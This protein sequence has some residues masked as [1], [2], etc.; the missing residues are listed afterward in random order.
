MEPRASY[1]IVGL[2][3]ISLVVVGIVGAFWLSTGKGPKESKFYVTYMSESVSGLNVQAPVKFNGV[4]VGTVK[5]ITIN[6][7]NS[8]QVRLLLSIE[9]DTPINQSTHA[10]L[11]TQGV[12]GV[13]FVGLKAG[14]ATA[15][16]LEIKPGEQYPVIPS[17]PSV[18][19]EIGTVLRK[20]TEDIG[21]ISKSFNELFSDE[22]QKAIHD[23]LQHLNNALQSSQSVLENF[24]QQVMPS[25]MNSMKQF[26]NTMNRM[27]PVVNTLQ[28]NP[29]ALI[30]GKEPDA[31]GP[32]EK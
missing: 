8:Q 5:E 29:S 18:L 24:K 12:T 4:T 13:M 28:D 17:E 25:L 16:P 20:I 15:P 23:N 30:R 14:A 10:T 32:G 7:K 21:G 22:N 3:V 26:E 9:E 2:F 6:P 11:M 27:E 19:E 1:F 31:P